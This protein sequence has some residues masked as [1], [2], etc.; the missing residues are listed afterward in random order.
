MKASKS[1]RHAIHSIAQ[2]GVDG[3]LAL[4]LETI[5]KD[6]LRNRIITYC[7]I[8]A[9]LREALQEDL[10][11]QGADVVR[12]HEDSMS[13]D[14]EDNEE[15][16]T[17]ETE[18]EGGRDSEKKPI[19]LRNEDATPRWTKCLNCEQEFDVTN[20]DRGDCQWHKG[21]PFMPLLFTCH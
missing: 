7:D 11:V 16:S 13:E 21:Q 10:V 3:A 4:A 20:N 2:S 19:A 9:G 1:S 14:A 6:I 15:D 5:S 8:I 17:S 18:A 12:Y